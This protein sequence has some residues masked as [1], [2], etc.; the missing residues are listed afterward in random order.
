VDRDDFLVGR[1]G[2]DVGLE[3]IIEKLTFDS[4]LKFKKNKT[5]KL[6]LNIK[7]KKKR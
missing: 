7:I 1:V 5:V 3:E 6:N 4:F 2:V